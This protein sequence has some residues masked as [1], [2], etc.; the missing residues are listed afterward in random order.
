[1]SDDYLLILACRLSGQMSECQWE[2]HKADPL[3]RLWL[4]HTTAKTPR[5]GATR[6]EQ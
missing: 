4:E 6:N 1:M 3:F 2:A 5:G